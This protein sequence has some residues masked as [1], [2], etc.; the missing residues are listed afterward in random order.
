MK[1]VGF[2]LL[3]IGW[4]V[5]M[6]GIDRAATSN[7]LDQSGSPS[8]AVAAE[9]NSPSADSQVSS[10]ER[11]K[12]TVTNIE[13]LPRFGERILPG[14]TS[15]QLSARRMHRVIGRTLR[16]Q[17][18]LIRC[19][20]FKQSWKTEAKG[21]T[22]NGTVKREVRRYKATLNNVRHPSSNPAIIGGLMNS[23]TGKA[24]EINGTDVDHRL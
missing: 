23:K 8:A 4:I 19:L 2:L 11:A 18:L 24:G 22:Q 16:H 17:L 9:R 10:A 12:E 5:L 20:G 21:P 1:T 6:H 14:A 13:I 15:T 3:I 7:P